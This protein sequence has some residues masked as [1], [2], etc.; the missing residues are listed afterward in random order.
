[1]QVGL[2]PEIFFVLLAALVGGLSVKLF[3]LQPI[4]GYILGG[5]I[6]G[7]IFSLKSGQIEKIAEIGAILLLF[8][9]G[10]ELSLNKLSKVVKVSVLGGILQML[11]VTGLLYLLL[12]LF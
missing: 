10:I 7:S 2:A 5:V 8:S 1:M 3:K 12:Q 9:S 4:I 11:V 6:F